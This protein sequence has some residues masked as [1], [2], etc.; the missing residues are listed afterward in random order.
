MSTADKIPS[1]RASMDESLTET[2]TPTIQAFFKAFEARALPFEVAVLKL[3]RVHDERNVSDDAKKKIILAK[4]NGTEV[5][6][7]FWIGRVKK[8]LNYVEVNVGE[9]PTWMCRR[10]D[11]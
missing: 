10:A 7:G 1:S 2:R 5:C 9:H 11:Q 4:R 3:Q 8:R 6:G